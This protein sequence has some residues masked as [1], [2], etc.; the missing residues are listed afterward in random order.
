MDVQGIEKHKGDSTLALGEYWNALPYYR[1]AWALSETESQRAELEAKLYEVFYQAREW[2]SCALY[3]EELRYTPLFDSLRYKG[4]VYWRL[5]KYEDILGIADASPLLRA[6]AALRMGLR[7]SA[8]TLYSEAEKLLDEIA[9]GRLAE[10]H[11]DMGNEDSALVLLKSLKHPTNTQQ[12][13]LVEIMFEQGDYSGLEVAIEQLPSKAERLTA[14]VRFYGLSGN[15]GMKRNSQIEL[16]KEA[17]TSWAALQAAREIAPQNAGEYFSVAMAYSSIDKDSALALLTRAQEM[18]YPASSCRWESGQILY[19]QKAYEEAVKELQGLSETK[20]RFLYV[21]ALLQLGRKSQALRV[22]ADVAETAEGKKDRQEAW[23]RQA[24]I[25]QQDGKNLE[26]AELA[27]RG[28]VEL[29]DEELGHR[30][31]VLW[32]AE[33]DTVSA[34]RAI[35]GDVPLDCDV[36]L[37]FRIWLVPDSADYLTTLLDAHNPFTYYS[38]AAR[39][40]LAEPPP[41]DSWYVYL[42]DT[43]RSLNPRDS[44]IEKGAWALAEAGFFDQAS[45]SLRKI[46]DAPI[47]VKVCWAQRFSDLGADNVAI[48]WSEMILSEARKRGVS[49]RPMEIVRL[50]YPPVY[51]FR[52]EEETADPA[53]FLA[54]TRQESWFHPQAKSSANAYGLCQLL[55]STA[56]GIDTTVT[57]DS[58]YV[59]SVSIRLGAEFLR[60]MQSRFEDRKVAYLGAYNAGPGAVNRWLGYLPEDNALFVELIPYDETRRYVQQIHSGEVI[61]RTLLGQIKPVQ[62][63]T[64]KS[65]RVTD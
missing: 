2:D 57:V 43:S 45:S 54:L 10:V 3:A 35:A 8:R 51:V 33:G 19:R 17:P 16:L 11:A 37:F 20:A 48:H 58:L 53:L 42:G 38:L 26:A 63:G 49:T 40:R 7:D 41:L 31:L 50:Q 15:A 59:P 24:T 12:R 64:A 65:Y 13:L 56:R 34:R 36:S 29:E 61:Y 22:L 21:K 18:G 4:L 55:L 5:G 14:L 27:A 30:A 1:H 44:V 9:R 28:A 39:G 62:M 23:E 46:E 47:P 52:I 60:R 32:L 25:L 6:E